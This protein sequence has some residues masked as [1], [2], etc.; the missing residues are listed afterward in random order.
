MAGCELDLRPGGGWHH[1]WRHATGDEIQRSGVYRE[2]TRPERIV[3]TESWGGDWP[4]RSNRHPDR[5][6]RW[7]HQAHHDRSLP[8]PAGP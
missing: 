5:G 2:V 3:N 6:K 1:E 7:R 8:V 4:E